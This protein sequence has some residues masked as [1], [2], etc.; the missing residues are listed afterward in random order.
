MYKFLSWPQR[1]FFILFSRKLRHINTLLFYQ[2][3]GC[4][5]SKKPQY[6]QD[7][8]HLSHYAKRCAPAGGR[9][10]YFCCLPLF[11]RAKLWYDRGR[12]KGQE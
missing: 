1:A 11:S 8:T 6:K 5:S 9:S 7:M 2:L 3:A 4:F 10:W 12:N